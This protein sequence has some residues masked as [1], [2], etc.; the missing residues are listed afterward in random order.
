MAVKVELEKPVQISPSVEPP[1]GRFQKFSD[2][3][4]AHKRAIAV[5]ILLTGIAMMAFG[6]G[7]ILAIIPLSNFTTLHFGTFV[8]SLFTYSPDFGSIT[9]LSMTGILFFSGIGSALVG[10]MFAGFGSGV[11]SGTSSKTQKDLTKPESTLSL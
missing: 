8:V 3:M 5:G 9:G 1:K 7:A 10:G 6:A 2:W 11:L 4:G